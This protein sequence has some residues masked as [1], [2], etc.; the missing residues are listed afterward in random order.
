MSHAKLSVTLKEKYGIDISS[1]SLMN[2]EVATESHSKALKN[3]GMSVKYLRCLADFYGVSTDY[4]LGLVDTP[5]PDQNVQAM[6]QYTGL[7]HSSVKTLHFQHLMDST[8]IAKTID[9]LLDDICERPSEHH[10]RS[11]LY[12]LNFFLDFE[13]NTGITKQVFSNGEVQDFVPYKGPDG[14]YYTSI[15]SIILDNRRIENAILLEIQQALI[16][17]KELRNKGDS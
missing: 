12:L 3:L 6:C 7:S 8:Q 13:N 16:S 9:F 15:D 1:D 5:S 10:F 11:I 14:K 4:L 2:Y 17:L